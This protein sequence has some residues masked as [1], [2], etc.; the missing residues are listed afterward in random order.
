MLCKVASFVSNPPFP[1][2]PHNYVTACSVD[3]CMT[4]RHHFFLRIFERQ[5]FLAALAVGGQT[6]NDPT[7]HSA[8]RSW[9]RPRLCDFLVVTAGCQ[10]SNTPRFFA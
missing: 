2:V 9:L 6:A 8:N 7:A 4:S 5:T 3:S 1:D 10:K